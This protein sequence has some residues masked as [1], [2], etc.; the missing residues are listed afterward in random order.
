MTPEPILTSSQFARFAEKK[1]RQT[2]GKVQ[3]KI[4]RRGQHAAKVLRKWFYGGKRNVAGQIANFPETLGHEEFIQASHLAFLA[5]DDSYHPWAKDWAHTKRKWGKFLGETPYESIAPLVG[6]RLRHFGVPANVRHLLVQSRML[7]EDFRR[8]V[9]AENRL[10]ELQNTERSEQVR[11]EEL[12]ARGTIARHMAYIAAQHPAVIA[13]NAAQAHS[14]FF[15]KRASQKYNRLGVVYWPLAAM[16]LYAP[17]LEKGGMEKQGKALARMALIKAYPGIHQHI[18]SVK[19]QYRDDMERKKRQ[20]PTAARKAL[21]AAVAADRE[22]IA[23]G[24]QASYPDLDLDRV[25]IE[26]LSEKSN[27]SLYRTFGSKAPDGAEHYRTMPDVHDIMRTRIIVEDAGRVKSARICRQVRL[28]IENHLGTPTFPLER[29]R[30]R[31]DLLRKG[32]KN[33]FRSL[34]LELHFNGYPA[35][36]K[37]L[38]RIELQILSRAM[39]RQNQRPESARVPRWAYFQSIIP[40]D[41]IAKLLGITK[42][43]GGKAKQ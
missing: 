20:W 5:H 18:E 21:V 16:A 13:F 6:Y 12:D 19:W 8:I 23:R 41:S 40:G 27:A 39:H 29:V 22:K 10:R 17:Y 26:S 25:T 32:K 43:V 35:G 37:G 24:E 38:P 31:K 2:E 36:V 33:K 14:Y 7:Q 15:Q 42:S 4:L 1:Y 11:A 30:Q 34:I 3:R 28:A 9:L